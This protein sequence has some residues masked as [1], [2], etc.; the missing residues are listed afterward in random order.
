[1]NSLTQLYKAPFNK[2]RPIF[3]L[4]R[5]ACWKIIRIFKL[6]NLSYSLWGNKKIILNY[7]SF[8][9]MW[10]MYNYIVDW[11]EF[12][13]IK[14]FL[15]EGDTAFDIGANMGFYTIWFS[16]FIKNGH[17]HSFEPDERNYERLCKNIEIN[18]MT[19]LITAH[20]KAVSDVND[21]ILFSKGLDGE[22]HILTGEG[23]NLETVRLEAITLDSFCFKSNVENIDYL[24]IDVEGFETSVLLGGAEMFRQKRIAIVQLELNQ[25]ILN[26]GK[27]ITDI[28]SLL[29]S[30][31]YSL[32]SYDI[33]RNELKLISYHPSRENYFAVASLEA[34]NNKLSNNHHLHAKN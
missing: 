12:N 2:Q 1:M 17:I 3:A 13:L 6:R 7:D 27:E 8:Q 29:E 10:I 15:K 34:I 20:K 14:R 33:D 23:K 16:K 11:E 28:L 19:K 22:N 25:A 21:T 9:S 5:F 32:C 30:Y 26:S 31:D 24:K 18:R 4:W